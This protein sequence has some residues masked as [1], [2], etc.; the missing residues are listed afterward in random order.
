MHTP[1]FMSRNEIQN[2]Y[3]LYVYEMSNGNN[4]NPTPP[5]VKNTYDDICISFRE[6]ERKEKK[7]KKVSVARAA[8]YVRQVHIILLLL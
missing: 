3:S 8:Y 2:L 5:I 1:Y 7:K 4:S 6:T